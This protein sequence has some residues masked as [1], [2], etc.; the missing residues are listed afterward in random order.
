MSKLLDRANC[1]S[2]SR[3]VVLRIKPGRTIASWKN[4][5]GPSRKYYD[6][7]QTV[8]AGTMAS[9]LDAVETVSPGTAFNMYMRGKRPKQKHWYNLTDDP[10]VV[11]WD[12]ICSNTVQKS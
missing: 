11:E 2:F 1:L 10:D 3:I 12:S 7:W 5:P 4:T 9:S 8:F 6:F